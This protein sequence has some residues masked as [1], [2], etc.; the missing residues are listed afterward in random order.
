MDLTTKIA[1]NY[2]VAK[3]FA[4]QRALD[5]YL[6]EHPKADKSQHSVRGKGKEKPKSDSESK[7][8]SPLGKGGE[9]L[10]KHLSPGE[11]KRVIEQAL[12]IGEAESK[13]RAPKKLK[14][15]SKEEGFDALKGLSHAD[16]KKVIER[17]L[18][19]K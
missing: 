7:S 8:D 9:D 13:G 19:M 17:A 10:L 12:E 1:T 16:Q 6:R 18:K 2:I 3:E 5:K 4:T 11:R 15:H 14:D